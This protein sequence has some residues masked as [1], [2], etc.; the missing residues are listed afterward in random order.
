M[1]KVFSSDGCGYCAKLKAY[2]DSKN[3]DY[4]VIDVDESR[5]N[6]EKLVEI[7]GQTGIPVAVS[8][9]GNYVIGFDKPKI[10]SM[11]GI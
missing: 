2:L 8:D 6:Y 1:I 4:E 11:L 3:V 5:E 7:S 10:D 9:S